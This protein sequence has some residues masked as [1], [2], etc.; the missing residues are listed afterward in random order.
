MIKKAV[1]DC[2]NSVKGGAVEAMTEVGFVNA[3]NDVTILKLLIRNKQREPDSYR[4]S[5]CMC[6]RQ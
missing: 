5:Q 4:A 6:T 3:N 2:F 1:I